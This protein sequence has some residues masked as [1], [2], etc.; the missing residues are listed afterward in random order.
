MKR[1]KNDSN[2]FSKNA[3]KST[4]EFNREANNKN[5]INGDDNMLDK[6]FCKKK[7]KPYIYYLPLTEEQ[8]K[9]KKSK[10]NSKS[11]K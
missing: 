10:S 9:Q 2:Y 11:Q 4:K 3:N 5:D 1:N 6:F 8:V 7:N